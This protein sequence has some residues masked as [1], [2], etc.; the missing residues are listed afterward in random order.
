MAEYLPVPAEFNG[1]EAGVFGCIGGKL[2]TLPEYTRGMGMSVACKHGNRK[3][4]REI[5]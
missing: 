1:L 2:S 3:Q 5:Y 4:A